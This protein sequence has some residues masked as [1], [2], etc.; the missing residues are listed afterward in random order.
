MMFTQEEISEMDKTSIALG[1]ER[2]VPKDA[3]LYGYQAAIYAAGADILAFEE[4]GS[5]QGEWIAEIKLPNGEVFFVSGCYGSCS[6]CDAFQAEFG[7]DCDEADPEY[8][9]KLAA[10]GR[11]YLGKCMTCLLYTSPSPRDGATSRMP[12]SA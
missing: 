9:E 5:Y 7:W 2:A 11:D 10:F 3:N 8:T 1:A 4:F 6:G 12:S